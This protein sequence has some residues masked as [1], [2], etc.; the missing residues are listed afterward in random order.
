MNRQHSRHI[1]LYLLCGALLLCSCQGGESAPPRDN[2]QPTLSHGATPQKLIVVPPYV[3]R[4]WMGV[5]IAVVDKT[6][7]T[8][9]I[10][11]IPL[12]SRYRVPATELT[13]TIEAFLPSFVMEG[14]TMTSSSNEPI[15]PGAKVHIEEKNESVYDGWLFL[16]FPT[17][18]A[19]TN[20]K[21]GFS[22]VEA[23]PV[24]RK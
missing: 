2:P 12:N 5:K 3:V 10:Y 9:N 19:V 8:E 22:L 15:N 13:I 6:R 7:A 18:H 14:T 24:S 11:T 1:S 23:V 17:T 21:Y 20:P 4:S 16:K